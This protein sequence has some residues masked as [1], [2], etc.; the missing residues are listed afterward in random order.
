MIASIEGE[1][2][3]AASKRRSKLYSDD[4]SA[5]DAAAVDRA[6]L[7]EDVLP[8]LRALAGLEEFHRPANPVPRLEET[9]LPTNLF[10]IRVRHGLGFRAYKAAFVE[11]FERALIPGYLRR[12]GGNVTAAAIEAGLLRSALQRRMRRLGIKSRPFR[13]EAKAAKV[14][15][16]GDLLV[17]DA[18]KAVGSRLGSPPEG[19]AVKSLADLGSGRPLTF[20]PPLLG[21]WPDLES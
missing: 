13:L 1:L 5:F 19:A 6:L 2:S 17:V 3:G 9:G 8:Q 10:P 12:S 14:D 18:K 4:E 11:W 16:A 15:P 7:L 21:D 20:R